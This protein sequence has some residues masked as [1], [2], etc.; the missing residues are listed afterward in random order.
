MKAPSPRA[1]TPPCLSCPDL[2]RAS[3]RDQIRTPGVDCR[4]KPGNDRSLGGVYSWPELAALS[5]MAQTLVDKID[6]PDTG[7]VS[8]DF[9][10]AELQ[11][12][13]ADL[14]GTI[15]R[16]VLAVFGIQAV[17][18]GVLVAML[19]EVLVRS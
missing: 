14:T 11:A 18:V 16:V 19:I 2:I 13:R 6:H 17:L 3:I 9:L 7:L 1:H 15:W 4:V 10:R 8:R 5:T 12:L